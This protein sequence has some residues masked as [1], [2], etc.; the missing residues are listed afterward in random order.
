MEGD[1]S[2]LAVDRL[3]QFPQGRVGNGALEAIAVI[4]R[5]DDERLVGDKA[6]LCRIADRRL[7][8]GRDV[9]GDNRNV[10][11]IEVDQDDGHWVW[12]RYEPAIHTIA[13]GWPATVIIAAQS[14]P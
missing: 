3:N 7:L 12:F 6:G 4:A 13:G 10:I 8:V 11:D 14:H 5:R 1:F 9:A 2:L